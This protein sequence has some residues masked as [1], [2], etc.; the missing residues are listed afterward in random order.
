MYCFFV[1]CDEFWSFWRCIV[2]FLF[3]CLVSIENYWEYLKVILVV[4]VLLE[5]LEFRNF[6]WYLFFILVVVGNFEDLNIFDFKKGS[7]K[8]LGNL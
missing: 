3:E 4:D 8:F 2:L 5:V 6:V 7:D 1:L